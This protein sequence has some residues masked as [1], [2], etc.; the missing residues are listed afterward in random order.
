MGSTIQE[1]I[2]TV[3]I[4]K[5]IPEVKCNQWDIMLSNLWYRDN[6]TVCWLLLR[7]ISL[8]AKENS[9]ETEI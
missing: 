3:Q 1:I 2:V 9:I 6:D 5:C 8:V 7:K 4:G